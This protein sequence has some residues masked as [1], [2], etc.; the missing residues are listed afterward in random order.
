MSAR[1]P[2][3]IA[4]GPPRTGTTWLHGVLYHRACLPEGV[5]ETRFFDMFYERGLDWYLGHFQDCSEEQLI[6]EISPTYFRWDTARERI[7]KDLG[8]CKII[9]TLREPVSRAYSQYRQLHTLGMARGSFESELTSNE[10]LFE[11]TRY[12]FHLRAWYERFGRERV[13][14]FFYDDLK[15]DEQGF[16]DDVCR[17]IGIPSIALT[18]EISRFLDRNEVTQG[19]RSQL[20]AYNGRR[21]MYWLQRH[22]A[23]RLSQGLERLGLWRY[24]FGRGVSFPPLD[25]AVEARLRERFLPEVEAVEELTLR[26]LSAWKQPS[27]KRREERAMASL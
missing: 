9:C 14:V 2:H 10:K 19:S 22:H 16:V 25:A 15:V 3:F 23:Y 1:L 8:S 17:F 21:L 27:S 24:C 4:I 12:G 6:G 7:Y 26:D 13:G 11:F 18:P 20:L 5:K